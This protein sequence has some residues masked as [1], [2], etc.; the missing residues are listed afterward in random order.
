MY[1]LT[2]LL[3]FLWGG[4]VWSESSPSFGERL[5]AQLHT[6]LQQGRSSE[7]LLSALE[8]ETGL[9]RAGVKARIEEE[10]DRLEQ[11]RKQKSALW[12]RIA[13]AGGEEIPPGRVE[14]L[15]RLLCKQSRRIL[16]QGGVY[17]LDRVVEQASRKARIPPYQ[18]KGLLEALTAVG[19]G[20]VQVE[21]PE[22]IGVLIEARNNDP[23]RLIPPVF[24]NFFVIRDGN[25]IREKLRGLH[26]ALLPAVK[27]ALVSSP[28]IE[29]VVETP[30]PDRDPLFRLTLE[31]ERIGLMKT[32]GKPGGWASLGLYG[33]LVVTHIPSQQDLLN[34]PFEKLTSDKAHFYQDP[35]PPDLPQMYREIA[36]KLRRLL[37]EHWPEKPAE[38]SR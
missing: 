17:A 14:K 1:G 6:A 33:R 15:V 29:W 34:I 36:E 38:E 16:S 24:F 26:R 20:A 28:H 12:E 31:I 7:E 27:E 19:E 18:G 4:A 22:Q 9:D 25:A 3:V 2:G 23:V 11:A 10:L 37:D 21:L 13:S 5:V 35:R 8:E 32:D 30:E